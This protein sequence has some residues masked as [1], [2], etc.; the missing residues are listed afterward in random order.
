MKGLFTKTQRDKLSDILINIG[1]VIFVSSVAPALL[2]IAK[3]ETIVFI[4]GF[5]LTFLFW[6]F[7]IVLVGGV[8]K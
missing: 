6:L 3:I 1:T 8:K 4:A 5:V 7:S 2:G